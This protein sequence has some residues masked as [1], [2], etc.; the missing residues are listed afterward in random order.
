MKLSTDIK[1]RKDGSVTAEI[2]GDGRYTFACTEGGP[3]VCD[4]TDE[5]HIAWLLDSGHFYPLDE[6]DINAGIAAVNAK[7]AKASKAAKHSA[8]SE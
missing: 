4:V 5:S 6:A 2:P 8:K 1:P 7:S 3:L